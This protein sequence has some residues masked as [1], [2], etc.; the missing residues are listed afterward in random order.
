MLST[1]GPGDFNVLENYWAVSL[2][3]FEIKR[4]RDKPPVYVDFE[5]EV[6]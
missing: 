4:I 1:P 5:T 2:R 3:V 6:N